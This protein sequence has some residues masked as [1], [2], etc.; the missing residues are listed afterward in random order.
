[1]DESRVNGRALLLW[2]Q[3]HRAGTTRNS[4]FARLQ[5]AVAGRLEKLPQH[6]REF[7]DR[8]IKKV[9]KKYYDEPAHI[10]AEEVIRSQHQALTGNDITP[11]K[12]YHL[13]GL[14]KRRPGN[15]A[16]SLLLTGLGNP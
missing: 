12:L 8:A 1:M 2:S 9:L 3:T 15:H 14:A 11:S 10:H 6:K 7:A 16:H 13:E 5:K 4:T